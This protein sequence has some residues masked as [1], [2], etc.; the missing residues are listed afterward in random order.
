MTNQEFIEFIR[1]EGEEWRDVVGYEGLY[2]VSSFG[3]VLSLEKIVKRRKVGSFRKKPQLLSLIT[4][5]IGY[6]SV[7]LVK[8]GKVNVVYVHRLVAMAFLQNPNN[9]P[10]VDHLDTNRTNNH[11]SNLRWC[12]NS[13]NMLNPF[14]R[15][16]N[17]NSKKGMI[18]KRGNA[19]NQ[20]CRKVVCLKNGIF[21]KSFESIKEAS[22]EGHNYNKIWFVCNGWRK[23]HHGYQWMYLSDYEKTLTKQ[24]VNELS[25]MQ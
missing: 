3:R 1:L 22:N 15:I 8:N 19:S 23:H 20:I 13:Q 10:Q 21:I 9:Y 6:H 11:V 14:T 18:I 17:S 5:T 7:N 16:N 2:K 12:T 24:D 4:M 25:P